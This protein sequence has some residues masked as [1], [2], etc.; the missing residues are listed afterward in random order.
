MMKKQQLLSVVIVC[1][2]TMVIACKSKIPPGVIAP[3]EMKVVMFDVMVAEQVEQADTSAVTKIHQRD[4]STRAI[5]K[6]LAIH[7]IDRA[8]YFKSLD[9]YEANPDILK[10]L[11]DSTKSYGTVLQDSLRN[12]KARALQVKKDTT[13][14]LTPKDSLTKKV[15]SATPKVLPIVKK[16][17]P[18]QI[19]P[20]RAPTAH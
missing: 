13:K 10:E 11:L 4:S 12:K 15:D 16:G 6:V 20:V 5:R 14:G 2:M 17:D 7:H 1:I 19:G 3:E 9:F 18:S 8:K